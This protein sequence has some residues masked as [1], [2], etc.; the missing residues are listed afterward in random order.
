[1][2]IPSIKLAAYLAQAGVAARRRSEELI[3]QG[4]VK[5][6][7]K[8][9]TNVATRVIPDQDEIEYNG[10]VLSL[11]AAKIL[12][13]LNKPRGVVSTVSDPDGKKTVIDLLPTE[14]RQWRLFPIGRLDEDSEGLILLTNDGQYAQRLTHPRYG[15]AKTYQV[16]IAGRLT[17]AEIARLKR[18]VPLKDGRT[19]PAQVEIGDETEGQQTILITLREGRYHEVRRMMKALNHAVIRLRRLSVGP[20]QLNDLPLGKVRSEKFISLE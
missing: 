20:F 6:N 11:V 16:I 10:R 4:K 9:E 1:M 19:G 13:A 2:A 15:V 7:G 14:Y 8:T 5:V 17:A 3:L 12:L 18:G